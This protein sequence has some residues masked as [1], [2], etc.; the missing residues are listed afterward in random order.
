MNSENGTRK[1]SIQNIQNRQESYSLNFS[2]IIFLL[3]N[4]LVLISEVIS[5]TV[6]WAK[7]QEKGRICGLT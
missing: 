7:E 2:F 6:R 1:M 3:L 5:T 4:W